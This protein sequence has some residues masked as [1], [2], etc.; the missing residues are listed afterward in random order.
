MLCGS[1][2]R[3]D[4]HVDSDWDVAV[5]FRHPVRAIDQRRVSDIGYDVMCETGAIVQSVALPAARWLADD[6][7]IRH[8][9]REGIALH[10]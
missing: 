4:W 10:G 9:R 8:L 5:F 1:R 6:E 7:F 3:G 2:A